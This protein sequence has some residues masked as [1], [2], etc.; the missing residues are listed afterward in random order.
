MMHACR[1]EKKYHITSFLNCKVTMPCL[2]LQEKPTLKSPYW[3]PPTRLS[4]GWGCAQPPAPQTHWWGT[5]SHGYRTLLSIFIKVMF[6]L[7]KVSVSGDIHAWPLTFQWLTG[8]CC[9]TKSNV[10][11]CTDW[12]YNT[13]QSS[14]C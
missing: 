14:W 11:Q 9:Q 3:R 6:Y 12:I 8:S 7:V 13:I 2:F 10:M 5:G 4:L 1:N